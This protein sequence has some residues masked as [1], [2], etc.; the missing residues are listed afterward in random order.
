VGGQ[1]V[2]KTPAVQALYLDALLH[3]EV[4]T[5]HPLR[6]LYDYEQDYAAVLNRIHEPGDPLDSF[7]IGG[8]GYVFPRYVETKYGGKVTVAEIDPEVTAVARRYFRLR[9]SPLLETVTGDARLELQ[10]RPDSEKFDAV[11]GDAFDDLSVPYHLT[12]REFHRV[13]ARHL[14][15]SGIYMLN[16]VDGG[17]LDFLRSE[18]RTLRLTFPYVAFIPPKDS[19]PLR[20]GRST[21][22]IVAANNPPAQPFRALPAKE[23]DAFL[24]SGHSIVLTD[25]HAPV[26]Q[27]LAPLF[28]ERLHQN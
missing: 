28:R 27:L 23:L 11:F 19:W 4:D 2:E 8:G 3:S 5:L 12:T 13:V 18:L 9:S 26:E 25:D 21:F 20:G 17:R 16:V 14:R 1:R 7:F 15:P 24:A 22:V 10:S 6:L